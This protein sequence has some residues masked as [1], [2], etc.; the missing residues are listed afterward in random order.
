MKKSDMNVNYQRRE[1]SIRY[2][3]VPSERLPYLDETGIDLHFLKNYAYSPANSSINIAV[4]VRN[5]NVSSLVLIS[6]TC[7]LHYKIIE[8]A[9]NSIL[10]VELFED[11][12]QKGI[13]FEGRKLIMDNARIHK[14][15]TSLSHLNS[16]NISFNFLPYS[17]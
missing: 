13:V 4:P 16:K 6:N 14:S 1:Y 17:P 2:R 10:F 9:I 15:E 12:F 3:N 8:G 11:C 7:I 5:R